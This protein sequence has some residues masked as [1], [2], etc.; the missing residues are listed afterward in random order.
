MNSDDL[1]REIQRLTERIERLEEHLKIEHETSTEPEEPP[2]PPLA[3]SETDKPPI[4]ESLTGRLTDL[5]RDRKQRSTAPEHARSQEVE[6]PPVVMEIGGVPVTPD[7]GA[8]SS[9][10]S[11]LSEELPSP[12]DTPPISPP[13]STSPGPQAPPTT[14]HAPAK[15]KRT[16]PLE[17]VIG[18]KW[19]AWVGAA[20]IFLAALFA[21]KIA[22]D[23]GLWGR[24]QPLTKCFIIGGFG[25]LLIGAGELALRKVGR[26]ASVGLFGAGISVLYLDSFASYRYFDLLT[27]DVAFILM[28]IVAVAGFAITLRTRFLTIGI[29]AIVGGYLT[30]FL[31]RGQ[32]QHDLELLTYLT[33]ML[34]IS[35]GLSSVSPRPFAPLRFLALAAQCI[36]GLGWL[37][38]NSATLWIMGIIFMSIWWTMILGES[39][40][41]AMKRHSSFGNVVMTLLATFAYI[42]AGCWV[43]YSGP[44]TGPD[45]LG[46]FTVMI[47]VLGVAVAVMFGPGLDGLRTRPRNALDKL[48]VALWVQSGV[49]LATAIALHF[50]DYGRA[51]GWLIIALGAIE[52]GRRM[53][54]RGLDIFGIVVLFLALFDVVFISWWMTPVLTNSI[55]QWGELEVTGW[56]ILAL[57]AIV[58]THLCAHR[59]SDR[60]PNR[61]MTTPA[62]LCLIAMLGWVGLWHVQADGSLVAMGWLLGVVALLALQGIGRRQRYFEI[63]QLVLFASTARWLVIDVMLNRSRRGWDALDETP[64]LN[65]QMG[66][67]VALAAAGWWVYRIMRQRQREPRS[68]TSAVPLGFFAL[69]R[70]MAILF[71]VGIALLAL[72]FEI[73]RIVVQSS[74]LGDD[75]RWVTGHV[76][77]IML[78]MLWSLGAVVL[79]FF[80]WIERRESGE[81]EASPKPLLLPV[82]ACVLLVVCAVKWI[83]LDTL[84]WAF[85]HGRGMFSDFLPVA[86]IQLLTG[87][88]IAASALL[89]SRTLFPRTDEG[90]G[91]KS[92]WRDFAA[93]IPVGAAV[94]ILW[95]LTFEIDRALF[96]LERVEG[97]ESLWASE[98]HR[99]LWWTGLWGLGGLGMMFIG[100]WRRL[101]LLIVAG[102]VLISM[103]TV[104]WL[105]YDTLVWRILHGTVEATVVLN[106]QFAIGAT[107]VVMLA[108][109][110]L[111]LG[112]VEKELRG[113]F[114]GAHDP[115]LLAYSMIAL[116]GLWLGSLE[117]DR[118]FADD[119]TVR[120]ASFSVYWGIYGMILVGLGFLRTLPLVRYAGL[121]LLA[122]TVVKVL[123]VDMAEAKNIWRVVSFAVSGLFLIVTSIAY[124]KL[125]RMLEGEDDEPE[126][127]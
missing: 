61:W 94:V 75:V 117:L 89:L 72:S 35:L 49:L 116:L 33:L 48:A 50:D 14:F 54:S 4:Q 92:P 16:T 23:Q 77:Q 112:R 45:W 121:G 20:G 32:F 31:L 81:R 22:I 15:P 115:Q 123:I 127:G 100:H 29:L 98:I 60:E 76:R 82:V 12:T 68:E 95:G 37:I 38:A 52:T 109:S 27:Q 53:P 120:L 62:V 73:D 99:M 41:A 70:Q 40:L 111:L 59:L 114:F 93:W 124:A 83:L 6:P 88:V 74:I 18:G 21:I 107:L 28:G 71:V 79:S 85:Y 5:K 119:I 65:E 84:Y 113:Q 36:T 9:V 25:L 1:M 39:I 10:M 46:I 3:S 108:I 51:A 17:M 56:S 44:N 30:P 126:A 87:L 110:P 34:G 64:L 90:E 86:N 63:A 78:T 105:T 24:L 80:T 13:V 8:E 47:A 104:A 125:G 67:A 122:I 66:M 55:R 2:H 91:S 102:L 118:L 106:L 101:S 58:A 7:V 11:E 19:M 69:A 26:A 97:Y 57:A 103:S 96:R 42:S 43:L